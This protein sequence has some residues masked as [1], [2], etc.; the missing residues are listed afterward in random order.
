[1]DSLFLRLRKREKILP[2]QIIFTYDPANPESLLP[3]HRYP[4][5]DSARQN[6]FIRGVNQ[7]VGKSSSFKGNVLSQPLTRIIRCVYALDIT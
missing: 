1:M 7:S 2:G 3:Q 5:T 4:G 6:D